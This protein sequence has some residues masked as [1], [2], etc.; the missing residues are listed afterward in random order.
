M[1]NISVKTDLVMDYKDASFIGYSTPGVVKYVEFISADVKN[2]YCDGGYMFSPPVFVF[3][4]V[5]VFVRYSLKSPEQ[6]TT[7][8]DGSLL[9]GS[10]MNS[11][12]VSVDPR[13]ELIQDY[14]LFH[15]TFF[16]IARYFA[17]VFFATF[18][19]FSKWII[20]GSWW[21]RNQAHLGKLIFMSVWNLV[22]LDWI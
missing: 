19:L 2:H 8:L 15:P 17:A 6:I 16:D 22:Q 11:L 3:C 20:H 18:S 5:W 10:G 14:F 12:E 7:D 21:K 13:Q 9:Y 4:L 1:A